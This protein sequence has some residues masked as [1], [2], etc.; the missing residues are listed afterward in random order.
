MRKIKRFVARFLLYMIATWKQKLGA[1]LVMAC[2]LVPYIIDGDATAFVF[3]SF[4]AVPAFFAKTDWI[5]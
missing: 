4:L 5:K 2:G 3:V 1:L